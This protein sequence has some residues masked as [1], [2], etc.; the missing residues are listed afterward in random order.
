VVGQDTEGAGEGRDID[1][2]DGGVLKKTTT[3]KFYYST[4][5]FQ[6]ENSSETS[7]KK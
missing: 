1:L 3:K 7:F 4:S 2:L 5:K 6:Y